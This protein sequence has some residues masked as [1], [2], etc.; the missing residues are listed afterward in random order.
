MSQR[1]SYCIWSMNHTAMCVCACVSLCICVT[2]CCCGNAVHGCR[3]VLVNWHHTR[4]Q[5]HIFHWPV[6]Q[7]HNHC[8]EIIKTHQLFSLV[9]LLSIRPQHSIERSGLNIYYIE[10]T[11]HTLQNKGCSRSLSCTIGLTK[12]LFLN[13][14]CIIRVVYMKG[15][16]LYLTWFFL[17]I[18]SRLL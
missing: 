8:K 3:C 9:K 2:L 5:V 13:F 1:D 12:N 11:L 18:S 6:S 16:P 17:D 14:H 4:M 15:S 10:C 7:T